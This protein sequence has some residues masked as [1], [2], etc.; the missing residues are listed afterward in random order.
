LGTGWHA[1]KSCIFKNQ[2]AF[3][4]LEGRLDTDY[5]GTGYAV[6]GNF[7][8]DDMDDWPSDFYLDSTGRILVTGF[9]KTLYAG[10]DLD[11]FLLRLTDKG[12][13]DGTFNSPHGYTTY[14]NAAG[15]DNYDGS[16]SLVTDDEGNIYVIGVSVHGEDGFNHQ[17]LALWRYKTREA[18]IQVSTEMGL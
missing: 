15:G 5:A 16:N 3:R 14:H 2:I 7:S 13:L 10:Y 11:V 4:E 8:G 9:T 18:W 1:K 12:S 17:D 6:V